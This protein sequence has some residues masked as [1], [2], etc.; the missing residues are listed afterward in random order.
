MASSPAPTW[1]IEKEVFTKAKQYL[2]LT[3][4]FRFVT[5]LYAERKLLVLFFVHL[6]TTMIVICECSISRFRN[7][8]PLLAIGP[9]ISHLHLSTTAAHFGLKKFQ[10][11]EQSV[12]EGASHYWLRRIGPPL[13]FGLMHASLLQMALI[14]LTMSRFSIA[15]LSQ[16]VLDRFVPLNRALRMHIHLG[17]TMVGIVFLDTAFFFTFFGI[18]CAD[19]EQ[20]YCDKFT[21]EIMITGY[22]ILAI[23]L[24]ITGT[25][26]FRHQIPYEIFYAVHHVVFLMYI[27]CVIHTF[28]MSQRKGHHSRSQTFKWFSSTLLYYLCDR[29][30]MHLNHKYQTRLVSSSAVTGSNG[31]RMLIIK[32]KRPVL[33]NF[34]PGQYAFLRLTELDQHWHPFSIASGPDSSCLEFY[35]EV[36]TDKSWTGKL[37]KMLKVDDDTN[38]SS[39]REFDLEVMG[40]Y[41]TSLANTNSYSHALAVGSG[42]GKC[43]VVFSYRESPFAIECSFIDALVTGIVPVLSLFKQHVHQLL[44]LDPAKHFLDLE[45]HQRKIR[46]IEKAEE[47]RKA[48]L[49]KKVVA[50]CRARRSTP[51]NRPSK[52]KRDSVVQSIRNRIAIHETVQEMEGCDR[53]LIR[54]SMHAMRSAARRATRSIYG[55][56]LLTTMPVLGISLIALTI[57]WNT[58]DIELYGGMVEALMVLTAVFQLIFAVVA[59]C[60]WDASQFAAFIDAAFCLIMPFADW[61]WFGH[62]EQNGVLSASD[63]T[64][65]SL[66]MGYL[67]ARVWSM[68]VKPRHRSWRAADGGCGSTGG[69]TTLERL[70]IVWVVRSASLVSEILP[71]ISNYWDEL[72]ARWGDENARAVCRI[73]VF[74]TDTDQRAVALLQQELLLHSLSNYVRFERPDFAEII[75]HHTLDMI[76]T[77]RNSYSVLSFCGSPVLAGVLHHLKI[78]N[79]MVA[80]VTGNKRH[81]MEFV[82]ESYGGSKASSKKEKT[83]SSATLR[84]PDVLMEEHLLAGGGSD[85]DTDTSPDPGEVVVVVGEA[86]TR[87]TTRE[88]TVYGSRNSEVT[89]YGRG[90]TS[91][92]SSMESS[93]D[94]SRHFSHVN[95]KMIPAP[96]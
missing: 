65:Y 23:L 86:P 7:R 58:I 69:L 18:L 50:S 93:V 30:A 42:T 52:N 74:V 53:Q 73:R 75:E 45:R 91:P 63:I 28:D 59:C 41:G 34:K 27:I 16:S 64:T 87:L 40:P 48:S 82:S 80:A 61:Y 79:D 81:Q 38:G 33:F 21:S 51:D 90:R 78:N 31:S 8:S 96:N 46:Q 6:M 39:L 89:T 22:G 17:Y 49:A 47:P 62:Y 94:M 66:L 29:A 37:W 57:S 4:W 36:F 5:Y 25:S 84:R 72:V 54:L 76:T 55:V 85:T 88:V 11:Q 68:T 70:E 14:P 67:T 15:A 24:I 26:Y 32:V 60:V 13:D 10:L 77:R 71:E 95:M 9:F 43:N 12:P 44:R 35:I 2:P 56:V 1:K 92:T 83:A 3:P 20:A 19:G